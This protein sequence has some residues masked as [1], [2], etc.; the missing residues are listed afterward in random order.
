MP[1]RLMFTK[2]GAPETMRIEGFDAVG[3]PRD[4][5]RHAGPVVKKV[6]IDQ[7]EIDGLLPL[8]QFL[9]KHRH[10]QFAHAFTSHM[11]S[12]ALGRPLTY[13]DESTLLA[14]QSDFEKSGYKMCSLIKSIVTSDAFRRGSQIQGTKGDSSESMSETQDSK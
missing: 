5:I 8:K 9:L 1:K 6:K 11:L 12:Y 3:L 10:K 13:R 7:H 14:V 2:A 4:T